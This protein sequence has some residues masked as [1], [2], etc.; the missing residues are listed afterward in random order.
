MVQR[1]TEKPVILKPEPIS[2]RVAI[3]KNVKDFLVVSGEVYLSEARDIL[4][5]HNLE[6]LAVVT[7]D[8]KLDGFLERR[9]LD[10]LIA[11]RI[12]ELQK[13]TDALEKAV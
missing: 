7:K 12:I 1:V 10:K 3:E 11:T 9:L 2:I 8:G 6:Y 5:K 13:K 4:D